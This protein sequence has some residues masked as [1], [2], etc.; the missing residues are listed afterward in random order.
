VGAESNSSNEAVEYLNWWRKYDSS[1]ILDAFPVG[2]ME[3][4]SS[5]AHPID[6]ELGLKSVTTLDNPINSKFVESE[7][8]W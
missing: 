1:E 2:W 4:N 7:G 3:N 6:G 8:S 5:N